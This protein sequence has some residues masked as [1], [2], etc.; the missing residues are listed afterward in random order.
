MEI[1]FVDPDEIPLEPEQVRFQGVEAEPFTDNRRIRLTI[2]IT[3][4]TQP[5]DIEIVAT[6]PMGVKVAETTIIGAPNKQMT[7]T[8][9]LRG[10]VSEGKYRFHF[11]LLYQEIGIVDRTE[12]ELHLA[13]SEDSSQQ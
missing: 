6:N 11:S 5:P 3:P 7:L 13:G 8:L 1:E 2:N 12:I 10:D 9:H 4:F